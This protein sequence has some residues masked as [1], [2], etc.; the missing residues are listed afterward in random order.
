MGGWALA[1]ASLFGLFSGVWYLC[2]I[3][4]FFNLGAAAASRSAFFSLSCFLA[5]RLPG[6]RYF[7][8]GGCC[9]G[10]WVHGGGAL[11]SADVDVASICHRC[12]SIT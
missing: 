5:F 12:R 6:R 2:Y 3:R 7:I 4:F 1:G 10:A 11:G 9:L 8:T